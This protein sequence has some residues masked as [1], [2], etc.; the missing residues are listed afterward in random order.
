MVSYKRRPL[1]P[2]AL[3]TFPDHKPTSFDEFVILDLNSDDP[4]VVALAVLCVSISIRQLN[5]TDH[6][7]LISQLTRPPEI[8]IQEYLGLVESLIVNDNDY[9][10][11][12][13]GVE[14]ILLLGTTFMNFGIIKKTWILL[15]KAMSYC[16]LIGFHRPQK[17]CVKESE[18]GKGHR[19]RAWAAICESDAYLSLLLGLPYASDCRTIPLSIY[20]ESGTV[21]WFRYTLQRISVQVIDRDQMAQSLS[22]EETQRIKIELDS[23]ARAMNSNFWNCYT[24]LENGNISSNTYLESM[25]AQLWYHQLRV[26]LHMPLMI[27]SVEDQTLE[28]QRLDCLSASRDLL[29]IHHIMRLD[30]SSAFNRVKVIDYQAFICSALLVLGIL[31]Y[32]SSSNLSQNIQYDQDRELVTATIGILRQAAATSDNKI[33]SQALQ[34]L[35]TMS[36]LAK[37]A[38]RLNETGIQC[39][40]HFVKIVVPYSGTIL[41]SPGKFLENKNN[42]KEAS[43]KQLINPQP[44]FTFTHGIGHFTDR[45]EDQMQS[46]GPQDVVQGFVPGGGGG[47]EHGMIYDFPT[48]DLDWGSMVH[49]NSDEEWIWLNDI[50][51]TT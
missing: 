16:Q 40:N 23:S 10:S 44:I 43:T 31:G 12:R 14:V 51:N 41:I 2:W 26:S 39:K 34:G 25:S 50:N 35:E 49:M 30:I 15:H 24:H 22:R 48:I 21:P 42:T 5:T 11:T 32:G 37:A 19:H 9:A 27:Q 28:E 18:A 8:L 38:G 46:Q 1:G 47:N 17:L 7:H 3:D 29:K 6:R 4:S 20:G 13:E 45:H 33:A 36:S